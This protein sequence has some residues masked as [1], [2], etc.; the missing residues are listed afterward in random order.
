MFRFTFKS[1]PEQIKSDEENQITNAA[2]AGDLS[3]IN[4]CID[5]KD[6]IDYKTIEGITALLFAV[7]YDRYC[8]TKQLLE[9]GAQIDVQDMLKR[10][11]LHIATERGNLDI[12]KLLLLHGANP[13][14]LNI[15]DKTAEHIAIKNNNN[16]IKKAFKRDRD[17]RK[18]VKTTVCMGAFSN[19]LNEEKN[20]T[21][22]YTIFSQNDREDKLITDIVFN[23]LIGRKL[24]AS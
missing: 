10:T 2:I 13:D 5:R 12:V 20:N 9:A 18:K 6:N 1:S 24:Y 7:R 15:E 11:P 3:K 23:E 22:I 8:I 21:S 17:Y 19:T 16:K 4:E 14:I